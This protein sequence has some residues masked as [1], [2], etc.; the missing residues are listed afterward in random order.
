VDANDFESRGRTRDVEYLGHETD[1]Y[2]YMP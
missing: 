2:M 1:P